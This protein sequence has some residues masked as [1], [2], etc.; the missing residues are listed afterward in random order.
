[1][2]SSSCHC[3]QC[4]IGPHVLLISKRIRAEAIFLETAKSA[5]PIDG[6]K[7]VIQLGHLLSMVEHLKK[8]L[9]DL[10]KG[11]IPV[12]SDDMFAS[13]HLDWNTAV[14]PDLQNL[15]SD[16]LSCLGRMGQSSVNHGVV[17]L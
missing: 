3:I 10:K 13:P 16:I 15:I 17:K 9:E 14:A 12:E 11:R 5:K 6:L 4:D 2:A 8:L 1:M 7:S